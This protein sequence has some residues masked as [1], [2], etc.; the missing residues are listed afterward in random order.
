MLV[1]L[2]TVDDAAAI[3][4]IYN[5]EGENS[6]AT[7]DLRPRTVDGQRRWLAERSGAYAAV[8]AEIDGQVAGFASLSPYRQRPAYNT[9]VENSIYIST[10][11]RGLGVGDR[12]MAELCAVSDRHGFHSMVARIG[13]ANTASIALHNKHGFVHVGVEREIGRKFGR[14]LDVNVMQRIATTP[15]PM[16]R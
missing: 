15:R 11:H 13:D 6:T 3:A 5:H 14:W 7:F 1:R 9:T 10:T 16:D 12:L 2:A 4:E 8:V